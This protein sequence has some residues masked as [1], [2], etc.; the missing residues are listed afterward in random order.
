[1]IL[2]FTCTQVIQHIQNI[3]L[4]FRADPGTQP[5]E[6]LQ[7]G[8][9]PPC[10]CLAFRKER[11]QLGLK[12]P[13]AHREKQGH[14]SHE[15]SS[16]RGEPHPSLWD[17]KAA[18]ATKATSSC[19][20]LSH[21]SSMNTAGCEMKQNCTRSCMSKGAYKVNSILQHSICFGFCCCCFLFYLTLRPACSL[22]NTEKPSLTHAL[23]IHSS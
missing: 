2:S 22:L 23:L 7:M 21:H 18:P 17:H 12:Q 8:H 16:S 13:H 1:M 3:H 15:Q 11:M 9:L 6:W 20:R 14:N 5:T 19:P 4:C 10:Q